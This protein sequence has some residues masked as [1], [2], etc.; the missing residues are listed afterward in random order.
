VERLS[1]QPPDDLM[2]PEAKIRISTLGGKV[3]RAKGP[4]HISPG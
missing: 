4:F 1:F 3:G 2:S